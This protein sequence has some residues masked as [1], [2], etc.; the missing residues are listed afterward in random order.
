MSSKKTWCT[1]KGIVLLLII[2]WASV[3][4]MDLILEVDVAVSQPAQTK[5]HVVVVYRL[6]LKYI[7]IDI[8]R[9]GDAFR[10]V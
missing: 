1:R 9:S 2:R 10:L 4:H 8:V 6:K 5:P 7:S 3:E